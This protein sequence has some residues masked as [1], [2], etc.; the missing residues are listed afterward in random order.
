MDI[1]CSERNHTRG[2][3]DP[4]IALLCEMVNRY[5]VNQP[6]IF[7]RQCETLSDAPEPDNSIVV[8]QAILHRP[9]LKTKKIVRKNRITLWSKAMEEEIVAA[10]SFLAKFVS[11]PGKRKVF[12]Q[13]L[14]KILSI[15]YKTTF[16]KDLDRHRMIFCSDE[17]VRYAAEVSHVDRDK[18]FSRLPPSFRMYVDCGKVTC[19]LGRNDIALDLFQAYDADMLLGKEIPHGT[20]MIYTVTPSQKEL[21]GIIDIFKALDYRQPSW[22][23]NYEKAMHDLR[24]QL[25]LP[26]GKNLSPATNSQTGRDPSSKPCLI[27]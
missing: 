4:Q 10:A 16:R 9:E 7:M 3:D 11:P 15:S 23:R 27:F 26:K 19:Y 12:L 2:E 20:K 6:S 24:A 22:E 1:P 13:H 14:I 18:L 17:R 5:S 25:S 21:R 8:K